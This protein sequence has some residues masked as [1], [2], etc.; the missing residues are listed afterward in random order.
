MKRVVATYGPVAATFD[1]SGQGFAYYSTGI[2]YNKKCDPNNKN[3]VLLV[4]GYG[5]ENGYDY[6]IAKNR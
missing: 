2:Y 6:W 5:T 4:V 3:H 1:A